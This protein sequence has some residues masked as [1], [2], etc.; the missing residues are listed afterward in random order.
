MTE[1]QKNNLDD[2]VFGSDGIYYGGKKVEDYEN[3]KIYPPNLNVGVQKNSW[4]TRLQEEVGFKFRDY[5][6]P[7]KKKKMN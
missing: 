4:L 1:K 3:I 6:A 5:K 7:H 2:L